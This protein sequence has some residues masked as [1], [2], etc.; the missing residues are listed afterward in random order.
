M[1]SWHGPTCRQ[2]FGKV[3]IHPVDREGPGGADAIAVR[4]S[5][6]DA[7]GR[8]HHSRRSRSM[9]RVAISSLASRAMCCGRNSPT[10]AAATISQDRAHALFDALQ[11]MSRLRS[12][13]DLR[14]TLASAAG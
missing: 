3:R 6:D 11:N 8:P 2:F 4:P 13:T 14:P 9:S 10:C 12:I 1:P 7:R 5:A